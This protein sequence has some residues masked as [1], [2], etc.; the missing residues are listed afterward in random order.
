MKAH[1]ILVRKFKTCEQNNAIHF[2]NVT[3]KELNIM[4][5]Q[6]LKQDAVSD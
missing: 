6:V 2:K 5:I 1:E 3:F 4:L